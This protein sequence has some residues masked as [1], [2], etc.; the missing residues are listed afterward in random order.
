M[1]LI[2]FANVIK[3]SNLH[4]YL[5]KIKYFNKLYRNIHYFII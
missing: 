3:K 5:E 1:K 4:I 2:L